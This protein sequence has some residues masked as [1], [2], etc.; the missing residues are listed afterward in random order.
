MSRWG[1]C[2]CVEACVCVGG[3]CLCSRLNTIGFAWGI[4][5]HIAWRTFGEAVGADCWLNTQACIYILG[6]LNKPAVLILQN[7]VYGC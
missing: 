4:L 5:I 3:W 6:T 7:R 2:W 1:G